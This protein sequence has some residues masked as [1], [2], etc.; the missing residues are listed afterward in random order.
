MTGA[1]EVTIVSDGQS[2]SPDL[3]SL[4]S[5]GAL[6][7]AAVAALGLGT[8]LTVANQAQAIFGA[9]HL[10]ILPLVLV[11]LTPFVVVTVSQLLGAQQAKREVIDKAGHYAHM[12]RPRELAEV[13]TRFL[14]EEVGAR[15]VSSDQ[16][17]P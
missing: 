16:R 13:A 6:S 10:Q 14:A 9:D 1:A 3:W 8:V 15:S 17:V 11:Y 7:R 12:D 2:A 5:A 4:L